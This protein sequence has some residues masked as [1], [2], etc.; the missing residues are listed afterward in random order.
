MLD[1]LRAFLDAYPEFAENDL[2]ITGESYGG[3]YVPAVAYEVWKYNRG[4]TGKRINFKGFAI[5]MLSVLGN[6]WSCRARPCITPC[7]DTQADSMSTSW[8]GCFAIFT[9]Q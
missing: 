1:F 3:H 6:V 7:G 8:T 2:Y 5:G 9:H 4:G